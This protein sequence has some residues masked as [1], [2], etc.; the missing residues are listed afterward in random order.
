[1]K[2]TGETPFDG[3]CVYL[4]R[5]GEHVPSCCFRQAWE[6]SSERLHSGGWRPV[7]WIRAD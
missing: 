6:P 2:T 3:K 7:G 1:M 4:G 5:A